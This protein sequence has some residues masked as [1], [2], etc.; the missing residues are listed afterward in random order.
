[1]KTADLPS[2]SSSWPIHTTPL[3]T[4]YKGYYG[5]HWDSLHVRGALIHEEFQSRAPLLHLL[6]Q[7]HFSFLLFLFFSFSLSCLPCGFLSFDFLQPLLHF[8]FLQY[9]LLMLFLGFLAK[10]IFKAVI[11]L[12][13]LGEIQFFQN[14]PGCFLQNYWFSSTPKIKCGCQLQHVSLAAAAPP[15]KQLSEWGVTRVMSRE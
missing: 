2:K 4:L 14:L 13:L 11:Y 1:M 5:M 7:F 12:L 10:Y 6:L 8:F 9:F 15:L 3:I